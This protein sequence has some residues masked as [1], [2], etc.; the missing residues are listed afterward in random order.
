MP[1]P[2]EAQD[3]K[4]ARNKRCDRRMIKPFKEVGVWP[5]TR[6]IEHVSCAGNTDNVGGCQCCSAN[7][8]AHANRKKLLMFPDIWRAIG[9]A[10]VHERSPVWF[11]FARCVDRGI[12]SKTDT[13]H[14]I[15]ALN[16]PWTVKYKRASDVV[17]QITLKRYFERCYFRTMC[18]PF[19]IIRYCQ[20]S[21]CLARR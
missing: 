21:N 1:K 6:A 3:G 10:E 19:E 2:G 20:Q 9:L 13:M 18:Q 11:I 7:D 16:L 14:R 15:V 4:G 8:G 12:E 17:N 5:R